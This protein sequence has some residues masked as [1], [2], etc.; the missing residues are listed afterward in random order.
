MIDLCYS[1]IVLLCEILLRQQT[2]LTYNHLKTI[3]IQSIIKYE[4]YIKK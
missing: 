2:C 4:K 1:Q 3:Y